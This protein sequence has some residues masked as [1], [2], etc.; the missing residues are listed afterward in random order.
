MAA[1]DRR[2][3]IDPHPGANCG[4]AEVPVTGPSGDTPGWQGVVLLAVASYD[5][6]RALACPKKRPAREPDGAIQ[7]LRPRN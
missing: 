3:M 2:C 7:S 5:G 1:C 4:F 6:A